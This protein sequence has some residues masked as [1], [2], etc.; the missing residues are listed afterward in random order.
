MSRPSKVSLSVI[1][2]ILCLIIVYLIVYVSVNNTM[3]LRE[4]RVEQLEFIAY[5]EGQ[6]EQKDFAYTAASMEIDNLEEVIAGK[7]EL[8]VELKVKEQVLKDCKEMLEYSL[9]YVH[10]VQYVMDR[11]DLIYPEFIIE[12][13]LEEGVEI[14]GVD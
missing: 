4:E 7:D 6:V 3:T 14:E 5:L 13:I 9:T 2:A 10:F 8:I 12:S 1:I 11:N